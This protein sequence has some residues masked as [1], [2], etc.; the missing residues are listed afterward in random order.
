M[1]DFY[2]KS[3]L[4]PEQL[5]VLKTAF[6]EITGEPWF[7]KSPR[8]REQFAKCLIASF[9]IVNFDVGKHRSVMEASARMLFSRG[10]TSEMSH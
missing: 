10:E 3:T 9:P 6:D 8:A 2:L 7:N 4:Q 1:M 5:T